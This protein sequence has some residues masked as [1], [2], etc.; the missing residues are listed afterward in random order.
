MGNSCCGT[1]VDQGAGVK[2]VQAETGNERMGIVLGD[3]VGKG[4]SPCRDC[5]EAAFG[6]ERRRGKGG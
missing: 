4:F 3:G 1:F 6:A 5:L 2:A